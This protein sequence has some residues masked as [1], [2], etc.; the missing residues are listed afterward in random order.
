MKKGS[1]RRSI[2][3]L[4]FCI[5]N[6]SCVV[7]PMSLKNSGIGIG[8]TII[9]F[10]FAISYFSLYALSLAVYN[11]QIFDYYGLSCRVLGKKW[12]KVIGIIMAVQWLLLSIS[13]QALLSIFIPYIY[14]PFSLKLTN[15]EEKIYTLLLSNFFITLPLSMFKNLE[16][17]NITKIINGLG[18]SYVLSINL[19]KFIQDW[20][21]NHIDWISTDIASTSILACVLNSYSAYY[22]IP[23]IQDIL[24]EPTPKRI[25]K[26]IFRSLFILTL[27]FCFMTATTY[28]DSP[29]FR[30]SWVSIS[31][32]MMLTFNLIALIPCSIVT[33]RNIILDLFDYDPSSAM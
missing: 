19:L 11:Y 30:T 16:N 1:M 3:S 32:E 29:Y 15:N 2:F 21:I 8:L 27:I 17:T 6:P 12:G 28:L 33:V 31:S 25:K 20:P 23:Q 14:K 9:F 4:V 24:Y 13:Y 18:M 26:V 22:Y 5:L 10:G 7:L